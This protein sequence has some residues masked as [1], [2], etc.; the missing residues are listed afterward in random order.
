MNNYFRLFEE[1]F[2]NP[3]ENHPAI[4]NLFTG[5]VY[6]ISPIEAELLRQLELNHTVDSVITSLNLSPKG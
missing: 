3:K 6:E 4:Y 2:L 1:I 5:I